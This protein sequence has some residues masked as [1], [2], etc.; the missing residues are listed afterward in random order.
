MAV[1]IAYVYAMWRKDCSITL[2]D[3]ALSK[4]AIYTDKDEKYLADKAM[5]NRALANQQQVGISIE[6]HPEPFE[7]ATEV[8]DPVE[9]ERIWKAIVDAAR[10]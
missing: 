6:K 4:T 5:V 7:A 10:G 1:S 9:A 2:Y 8:P 3:K